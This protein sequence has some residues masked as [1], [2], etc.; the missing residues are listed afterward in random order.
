[1]LARIV[2]AL[3]M[4]DI[5][6]DVVVTF[7]LLATLTLKVNFDQIELRDGR[8]SIELSSMLLRIWDKAKEGYAANSLNM[9]TL[10]E[11]I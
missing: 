11:Q 10:S 3:N 7:Y 5:Q 4:P 8:I 6:L 1:M 2:Y 9:K